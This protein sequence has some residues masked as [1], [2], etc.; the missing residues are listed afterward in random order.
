MCPCSGDRIRLARRSPASCRPALLYAQGLPE[1]TCARDRRARSPHL[2]SGA[3]EVRRSG[4]VA[5]LSISL[6]AK[7]AAEPPA[8]KVRLLHQAFV[9]V[10][11]QVR[12]DLG[13]EVHHH[14]HHDQQ[15][16]AAE[17]EAVPSSG[18]A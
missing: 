9:L 16:S 18:R 11:H 7:A 17:V 15:R 3:G 8:F 4:T 10:R 5:S 1:L 6:A 13:G 14:H 2:L 12:L